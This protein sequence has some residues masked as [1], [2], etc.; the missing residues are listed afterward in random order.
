MIS[1]TSAS[2]L[3]F[4]LI[5]FLFYL[6]L[7]H[8]HNFSVYLLLFCFSYFSSLLSHVLSLSLSNSLRSSYHILLL[9]D[10]SLVIYKLGV[11][12][13]I[14]LKQISR[15]YWWHNLESNLLIPTHC[16]SLLASHWSLGKRR[17]HNFLTVQSHQTDTS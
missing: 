14:V 1:L 5:S 2:P 10:F 6:F 7:S 16:T 9:A 11:S 15:C 4:S 17:L 13:D 12:I 3:L 8:T